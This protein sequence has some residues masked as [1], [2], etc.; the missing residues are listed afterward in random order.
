MTENER[1]TNEIRPLIQEMFLQLCAI[2]EANGL[3]KGIEYKAAIK[4][5]TYTLEFKLNGN[6]GTSGNMAGNVSPRLN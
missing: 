4:G 3:T 1:L 6:E 2:H 5:K